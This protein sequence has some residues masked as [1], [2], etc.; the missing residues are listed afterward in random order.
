M[1]PMT[2]NIF[3]LVN[4]ISTI[5]LLDTGYGPTVARGDYFLLMSALQRSTQQLIKGIRRYKM[6]VWTRL[7]VDFNGALF[8]G[9]R[10]DHFIV[11]GT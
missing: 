8:P 2:T 5:R 10:L 1:I 4:M 6:I 9:V 3:R 11:Q 7:P